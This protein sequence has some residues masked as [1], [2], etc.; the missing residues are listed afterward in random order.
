MGW[1]DKDGLEI[2]GA[3]G[4][5]FLMVFPWNW[6]FNLPRKAEEEALKRK[7]DGIGLI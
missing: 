4:L 2:A 1:G 6:L 3:F 7:R 5:W